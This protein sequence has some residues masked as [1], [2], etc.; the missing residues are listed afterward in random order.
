[1]CGGSHRDDLP[2]AFSSAL[3]GGEVVP[4]TSSAASG[5][6]LVTV[7]ADQRTLNASVITSG[8]TDTA[9]HLHIARPGAVG[10]IEFA[11]SRTAGTTVWATRVPLTDA[12]FAALRD[13]NY[14]LDV[15]SAAFPEGEIRG[16]VVWALPSGDQLARLDQVRQQSAIVELQLR[17]VRD[18]EEFDDWRFTGIGLGFTIGF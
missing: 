18:I 10:P 5:A 7:D 15:H 13:G 11:L 6:G 12:Q 8:M 9:A 17:Q 14:Y 3:S 2:F 4:P 16:Q 1:A